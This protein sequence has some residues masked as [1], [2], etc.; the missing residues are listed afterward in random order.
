MRAAQ[1]TVSPKFPD[2]VPVATTTGST[3]P[4]AES[5]MP[6][7]GQEDLVTTEEDEDVYISPEPSTSYTDIPLDTT[8]EEDMPTTTE[9][10][11]EPTTTPPLPT[12]AEPSTTVKTDAPFWPRAPVTTPSQATP[13]ERTTRP[14]PPSTT[15][16]SMVSNTSAQVNI[17]TN[18][19]RRSRWSLVDRKSVV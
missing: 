12:T 8:T 11:P 5:A 15:Q 1:S 4:T 13:T 17:T 3:V 10:T 16:V 14:P 7:S 18:R 2:A 6:S 9:A 19:V